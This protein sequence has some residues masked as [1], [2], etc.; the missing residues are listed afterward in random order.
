MSDLTQQAEQGRERVRQTPYGPIQGGKLT[1]LPQFDSLGKIRPFGP[2]EFIRMPDGSFANEESWTVPVG[3]QW[4]VVPGLWMVNGVATHV[5]EDQATEY[6]QQSGLNWPMFAD[7]QK[8][9]AFAQQRE[10]IW[11]T[12][13]Q[14]RTDMQQPLWSRKWPPPKP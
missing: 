10:S 12:V 1:R 9:D 4:W 11:Q 3:N 2:G 14:G 6:A 8:A 7:Q 5:N 13:P